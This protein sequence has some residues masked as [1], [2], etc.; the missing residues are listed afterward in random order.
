MYGKMSRR[1]KHTISIF[2]IL[3]LSITQIGLIIHTHC[4]PS[5]EVASNIANE[6]DCCNE[7]Y[8]YATKDC[9]TVKSPQ[10]IETLDCAKHCF[11]T[12]YIG[13]DYIKLDIDQ[14]LKQKEEFKEYFVLLS[15]L[16]SLNQNPKEFS[17]RDTHNYDAFRPHLYG[18][19]LIIFLNKE[20]PPDLLNV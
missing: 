19:A 7:N 14:I 11:D 1:L 9:C 18:K 12:C 16:K 20:K 6:D 17:K 2:L 3:S 13:N 4:C 5:P 10:A 8:T 15:K